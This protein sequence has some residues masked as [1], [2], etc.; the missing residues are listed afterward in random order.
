MT[1]PRWN[2][3]RSEIDELLKQGHLQR[4]HPNREQADGQ[5]AQ[6]QRHLTSAEHVLTHL[7]DFEGCAA[8]LYDAAR[9]ALNAILS[10]EGLRTT[11]SGGHLALYNAVLAQLVPP[12]GDIIKPFDRLRR[13]RNRSEYQSPDNQ[14]TAPLSAA[15]LKDDIE[16]SKAIVEACARVLDAMPV[17]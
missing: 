16:K 17:F 14:P 6:A 8:L 10:N 7:N 4:V 1:V 2:Q 3:G 11:T 9:K 15:N 12:L 5:I 13:Q